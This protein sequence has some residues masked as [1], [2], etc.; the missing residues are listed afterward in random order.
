M[1]SMDRRRAVKLLGAGALGLSALPVP[2][3]S[4][5]AASR[6]RPNIIF[7]MT[8]DHAQSALSAYGNTIL[9]TPSLD[10]IGLEGIRFNNAFVTNSLCAP[11]RAS[12]LTG[13]YSHAHGVTT[14]G[15][16]PGWYEQ[17]GLHPDAQTWPKLLRE[18]GYQTAVVGKWHIKSLPSGFDHWAI[19]PGQGAYFDPEFIVNAGRVQFRGHTD[20]VIADQALAWLKHRRTDRP[21][22]LLCQFKAPH[23]PWEPA[24]RLEHEFTDVDIPIPPA[25]A[26]LPR[27]IPQA[28]RK[29]RMSVASMNFRGRGVPADLPDEQRKHAN[30]QVFVKNYYRV[31][32]G[33][34]ENVGRILDFLDEARIAENTIVIYTSDNGFF[35]GEFGLF[36]KRLMYEP[37]IR[38]PMMVRWP[39]GIE[40]H[41]VDDEHIVLNVD[42]APTL[43]ELCGAEV[44]KAMHGRS[45]KPLLDAQEVQWRDA[46]LYEFYEYPAVHCVRKHRGVRTER[47]KLIHF[48]EQPDEYALYDLETDPHELVNLAARPE[49]AGR[50]ALLRRRLM[51]LRTETADIDP[52][53]YVA[54]RVEPG[55]CP[56]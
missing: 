9:K 56:A 27:G 53:G 22:C 31:L 3:T 16:E 32:R 2:R 36:D 37:S 26:E 35:L 46:F 1:A 29:T 50:V 47:W 17:S 19:L 49:Q 4:R 45:W 30:L 14:N 5:S 21:F 52:P 23:S 15:E 39:A 48:W 43:L 28:V 12:F 18:A 38:V 7:M 10:R 40:R 8:D 24:P 54:P 11:S 34:D 25:F 6:E 55:K 20:D 44:P 41:R 13:L 51:E 33:V 42:V